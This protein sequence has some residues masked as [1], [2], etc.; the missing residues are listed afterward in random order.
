M[1]SKSPQQLTTSNLNDS[2]DNPHS[3]ALSKDS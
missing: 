1:T 2:P 3:K